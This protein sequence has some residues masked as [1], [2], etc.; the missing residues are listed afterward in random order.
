[1]IPEREAAIKAV[2]TTRSKKAPE[3]NDVLGPQQ[4]M[5]NL[6]QALTSLQRASRD[7]PSM[8]SVLNQIIRDLEALRPRVGRAAPRDD[9]NCT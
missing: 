1:L 3:G 5:R 8:E 7:F 4:N 6:D 2:V 9:L